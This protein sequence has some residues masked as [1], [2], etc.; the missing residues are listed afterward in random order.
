MSIVE[1]NSS[2][3]CAT[4][5]FVLT[6]VD[7]QRIGCA[8][9]LNYPLGVKGGEVDL[10]KMFPERCNRI[11]MGILRGELSMEHFLM[12]V[13]AQAKQKNAQLTRACDISLSIQGQMRQRLTLCLTASK[14][15][16]FC[17]FLFTKRREDL[18]SV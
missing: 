4:R 8:S 13:A 6:N 10:A 17:F 16:F 7:R 15:K 9:A 11:I 1:G 5:C 14:S 12:S 18:W 3:V 2:L